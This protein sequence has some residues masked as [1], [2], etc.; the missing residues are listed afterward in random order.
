[1]TKIILMSDLHCGHRAGMTPPEYQQSGEWGD[2]QKETWD[3]YNEIISRIGKADVVLVNGDLIEGK[4]PMTG[5]TELITSDRLE[6]GVMAEKTIR[7][8][9]KKGAKLIASYGTKIHGGAEEDMEE[10]PVRNLGG[11]IHSEPFIGVDGVVI[12]MRHFI[13]GS[14][15]PY[16]VATPLLRDV[17]WN[18]VWAALNEQPGCDIIVRSHVHYWFEA[19]GSSGTSPSGKYCA[20]ITPSLQVAKTKYGGRIKS[21][22]VDWGLY[23]IETE[24]GEYEC[25]VHTFPVKAN[26]SEL[27]VL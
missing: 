15:N 10:I 13:S 24:G 17:V 9:M 20:I 1:M 7:P 11:E 19:H 26:K 6:Q 18:I 2:V 23:E 3:R 21:N 8:A 4:L 27:I 25:H 16:G 5:G 14:A 22:H 12:G